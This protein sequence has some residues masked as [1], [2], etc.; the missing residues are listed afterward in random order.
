MLEILLS[1]LI[2]GTCLQAMQ[3][4]Q[5]TK[6]SN[7]SLNPTKRTTVKNNGQRIDSICLDVRQ[8]DQIGWIFAKW[9]IFGWTL[10]RS[11]IIT[12]VIHF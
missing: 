10:G 11:L 8:G 6:K 5:T 3:C 1:N 9:T 12:H 4:V 2:V 7:A